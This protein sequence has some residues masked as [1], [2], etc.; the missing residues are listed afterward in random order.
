MRRFQLTDVQLEKTLSDARYGGALG[1]GRIW[2][3]SGRFFSLAF[4]YP[5]I[6]EEE[7]KRFRRQLDRLVNFDGQRVTGERYR[8]LF[9]IETQPMSLAYQ[10]NKM[11]WEEL[12]QFFKES[13]GD[14]TGLVVRVDKRSLSDG[15]EERVSGFLAGEW[16]NFVKF[17]AE[18]ELEVGLCAVALIGC[19]LEF[20]IFGGVQTREQLLQMLKL[21]DAICE[22][23]DWA[24][25]ESRMRG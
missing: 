4:Q 18:E 15:A 6:G 21:V 9:E 10:E 13:L 22:A 8:G 1:E 16:E 11:P 14:L 20:R 12:L 3:G 24:T 17:C 25:V 2:Y 19:D 7:W 5:E 23:T